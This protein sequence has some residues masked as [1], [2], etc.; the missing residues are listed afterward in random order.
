MAQ[1]SVAEAATLVAR[2]RKTLYRMVKEGK[3]S[4]TLSDSR[5]R[6]IETSD[7]VRVFGVLELS[8]FGAQWN[9]KPG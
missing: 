8:G 6:Q 4:A 9:S 7:L 5:Q 1:L 2:D 3:L